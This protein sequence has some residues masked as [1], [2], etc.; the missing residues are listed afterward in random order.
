MK[1][2]VLTVVI[3]ILIFLLCAPAALGAPDDFETLK[4]ESQGTTVFMIQM[5]LR[6]LG[7]INYRAT[8]E[9]LSKTVSAVRSFQEY[10]ELDADGQLG[11]LTYDKLFSSNV[12][13]K[14]LATSVTVKSGPPPVGIP[15]GFG[16]LSDWN[17][18]NDIFPEG[19]AATVTDYN[20]GKSFEVKRVGG[21]GHADIKP[22]DQAA[23]GTF[24][25]CFGGE[26]NWEKRSVFVTV[27]G[28]KYAAS[29]FGYPHGEDEHTCLYF[30][31]STSDALGFVDKEHQKWVLRAANMP[32]QY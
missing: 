11:A 9:Y 31:N 16:Q 26:P 29:L 24:L 30:Y 23:Y 13:R 21:K 8:G 10:N 25:E 14:P 32:M 15:S 1:K 4:L 22:V 5:R 2:L 17:T 19:A 20:S 7:Y 18:I 12:V 27:G 28:V 3:T 6:D